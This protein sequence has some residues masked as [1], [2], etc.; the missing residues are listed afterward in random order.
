MMQLCH[1]SYLIGMP[2][3]CGMSYLVKWLLLQFLSAGVA[4]SPPPPTS[5]EGGNRGMHKLRN[6]EWEGV[7]VKSY[8]IIKL[9]EVMP[10]LIQAP[11]SISTS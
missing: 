11:G 4:F 3:K 8:K 2:L 5:V 6:E 9:A 7:L 1:T 10:G